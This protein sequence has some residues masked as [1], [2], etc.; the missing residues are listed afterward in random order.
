[1]LVYFRSQ[2][3]KVTIRNKSL[4]IWYNVEQKLKRPPYVNRDHG[5]CGP[6]PHDKLSSN[7]WQLTDLVAHISSKHPFLINIGAA[8]TAGGQYDPTHPLLT[9]MNVSFSALLID[10]NTD[11]SL[12]NAYPRRNNIQII[13]DFIWSESVVQNIFER[14]NVSKHFTI[15]K[16]DIDS[17]ECSVLESILRAG[18]RPELIHTEFNPI[19]PPPVIFIPIYNATTK[20]DWKPAL[21][22]N[23]NLFYGCSL[24]ALS[25][26]LKSFD[27][28]LLEVDF[29]DVIYIQREIA[30][31]T[32]IQ[33]PAND[34]IAYRHGFLEHSCLSYCKANAKLYNSKIE[35][36]IKTAWNQSNVTFMTNVID[37]FAPISLKT[38][39]KHPYI[40][41]P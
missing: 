35:N 4:H 34:H 20:N 2:H 41:S 28:I 32:Q 3:H 39:G 27:Y 26:L 8:S 10:P 11:S 6:C 12:F 29:W 7:A 9:A 17:Y 15:L 16:L 23:N 33:V 40:I 30:K 18:Y 5:F 1:M 36:A 24:S 14:Y 38:N 13:H 31:S 21:W 22:S 19:F 25:N 37:L